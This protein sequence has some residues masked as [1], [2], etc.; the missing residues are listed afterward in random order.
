MKPS[1][2][3]PAANN[4][5]AA[6]RATAAASA[7]TVTA[8]R[9]AAG[10]AS[11]NN[12]NTKL[13]APGRKYDEP[14][15]TRIAVNALKFDTRVGLGSEEMRFPFRSTE[16]ALSTPQRPVSEAVLAS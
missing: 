10:G 5:R 12:E 14:A 15:F 11:L 2:A 13:L 6:G 7:D 16:P 1:A 3:T 4:G 8:A 9:N